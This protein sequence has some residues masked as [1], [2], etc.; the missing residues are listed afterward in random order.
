MTEFKDSVE[1]ETNTLGTGPVVVIGVFLAG[2]RTIAS[3]HT[4]GA[5]VSYRI[6]NSNDTE[7]EVGKGIWTAAG[8]TLTR[9]TVSASSNSNLLVNFSAG[10]KRIITTFI[11]YDAVAQNIY[12][13]TFI[14]IVWGTPSVESSNKI[15]I[16]ATCLNID[17]EVFVSGQVAVEL[18]VSDS[19]G[20]NEPSDTAVIQAAT[21]PVGTMLSGTGTATSVFKT[22]N[23]GQ[24][25]I[26]VYDVAVGS[27]FVWLKAG[28]HSQL[29]C[30]AKDGILELTFT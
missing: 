5:T 24:F 3:A 8:S 13:N 22:N 26:A 4:S 30:R 28:G 14:S 16:L 19:A 17:N 11:A 20:S 7:W 23:A 1:D 12:V 6:N 27:R 10:I 18:R 9:V 15:E 21:A 25:K 29:F 2:R